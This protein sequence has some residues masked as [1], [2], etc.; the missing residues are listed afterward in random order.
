M[1]F[2]RVQADKLRRVRGGRSLQDVA[3]ASGGAFSRGLLWQWEN[4]YKNAEPSNDKIPALLLALECS[5]EDISEPVD[6]A[7]AA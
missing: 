4:S 5:F 2:R 6:V 7:V 3:R 1:S